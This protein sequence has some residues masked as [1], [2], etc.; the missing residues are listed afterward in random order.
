MENIENL[1]RYVLEYEYEDYL[2]CCFCHGLNEDNFKENS[3]H[4]IYACAVMAGDELHEIKKE[5]NNVK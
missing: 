4:H 5:K 1:I 3:K 2:D